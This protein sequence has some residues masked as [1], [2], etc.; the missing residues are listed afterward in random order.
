MATRI[1]L[2]E[3][4][5][6]IRELTKMLLEMAGYEVLPAADGEDGLRLLADEC[7]DLVILDIML[8]GID[9]WSV[10]RAIRTDPR[11][12]NLPILIFTVRSQHLDS[13]RQ[14]GVR[15][16]GF[17]NKPFQRDELLRAVTRLLPVG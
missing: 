1:L 11:I 5:E 15:I 8:P 2:V 3:D 4:D 9:G 10:C 16:D 14:A 6:D 17:L 13:D 12:A 7:V